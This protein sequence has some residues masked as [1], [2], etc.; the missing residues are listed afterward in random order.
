VSLLELSSDEYH[1]DPCD[2]PSLNSTTARVLLTRT[3]AHAKAQHPRL[4]DVPI[5]P[6]S[7]DAMD[8]GTAVHQLLLRD[9][10]IDVEGFKDYRTGEA[11]AWRDD[12]R[13]RGRVPMLTHQW[14]RAQA[15]AAAVREQM[16][17]L[18]EPTPFTAGTPEATITWQDNG[19]AMCRARLDWLRDDLTVIDDL[20]VTS[21]T[22]DPRKWEKQ[23]WNLGYDVQAAFYIRGVQAWLGDM[24]HPIV[25][26]FRWI[27]AESVPP[28]CVS[29]VTL[30]DADM[31]AANIACDRAIELW[32]QCLESGE[33]PGYSTEPHVASRPGWA[34]V[35]DE[36]WADVDVDESVPF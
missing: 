2:T 34:A 14:D 18:A 17:G 1:A 7:T 25:P 26:R 23:I 9:D 12:V 10:R 6:R 19:G 22:A 24:S 20:K 11:K 32:N 28:Y 30:S 3:A 5:E 31:F 33:W 29:V 36:S 27:V 15:I 8:M 35:P 4:A 13:S 16:R 21:K